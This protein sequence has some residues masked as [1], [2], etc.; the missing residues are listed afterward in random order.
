MSDNE[1]VVTELTT[2]D[3]N[4]TLPLLSALKENGGNGQ[5]YVPVEREQ[6]VMRF[7]QGHADPQ[8]RMQS[9]LI[10]FGFENKGNVLFMLNFIPKIHGHKENWVRFRKTWTKIEKVQAW[11]LFQML[12]FVWVD[13]FNPEHC[14]PRNL[15]HDEMTELI[16]MCEHVDTFKRHYNPKHCARFEEMLKELDFNQR[17]V[18]THETFLRQKAKDLKAARQKRVTA[19]LEA[20]RKRCMELEEEARR[21][22]QEWERQ[23]QESQQQMEREETTVDSYELIEEEEACERNYLEWKNS[24]EYN[25][26]YSDD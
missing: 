11:N 16:D 10:R 23:L 22:R 25:M 19:E 4:E 7:M 18:K 20:K 5:P 8:M 3:E 26:D 24:A 1:S 13:L 2:T 12:R 6:P 9:G 15:S 17:S 14:L 21:Q